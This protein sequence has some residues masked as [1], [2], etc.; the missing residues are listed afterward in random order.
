MMVDIQSRIGRRIRDTQDAGSANELRLLV[1][2]LRH[3]E[4]D[5]G[6]GHGRDHHG[7]DEAAARGVFSREISLRSGSPFS[8]DREV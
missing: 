7:T 6:D 8:R 1:N 5:Q 4:R 2:L 3:G